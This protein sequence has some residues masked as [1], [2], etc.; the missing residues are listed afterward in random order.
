MQ[1]KEK[2]PNRANDGLGLGKKDKGV[3]QEVAPQG[4]DEW[5][6]CLVSLHKVKS[7]PWLGAV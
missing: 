6:K 5:T 4:W 2:A 3:L 7:D 1:C